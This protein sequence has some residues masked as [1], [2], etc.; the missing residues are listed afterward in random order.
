MSAGHGPTAAAREANV[1]E[2]MAHMGHARARA[3]LVYQH[4]DP[5]REREIAQAL[6]T[7]VAAERPDHLA[8]EWRDGDDEAGE[9]S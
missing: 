8:R 4:V 5:E 6:S 2:L 9:S 7:K 3:A 1:K